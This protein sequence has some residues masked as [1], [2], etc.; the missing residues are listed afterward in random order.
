MNSYYFL[1][2][3]HPQ[4]SLLELATVL[5]AHGI[6]YTDSSINTG[7]TKIASN[8]DLSKIFDQIGG[9]VKVYTPLDTAVSTVSIIATD[10]KAHHITRFALSSHSPRIKLKSIG[11]QVKSAIPFRTQFKL[12][13]SPLSSVGINTNYTEYCIVNPQTVLKCIWAQNIDH[14][15]YKDRGRPKIDAKS[16]MLPLKIARLMV[17][18]SL[19]KPPSSKLT[20]YDPFCGSG[21]ILQEG[22]DL[23]L[24]VIGSDI[25]YK[26]VASSKSNLEWYSKKFNPPGKNSVFQ[27]DVT[28][29]D[30]ANIKQPINSIVFEG[31]LGPPNLRSDQI[32]NMHK[33]LTNLYLGTLK[34][35]S[36]LLAKGKLLVCAL[37]QYQHQGSVK[38]FDSLI[39]RCEKFGYTPKVDALTY[40][41]PHAKIK[42][43]IYVLCKDH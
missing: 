12:L 42:R 22:L 35:L 20:L 5:S 34:K 37:P 25:N 2:G 21:S 36:P 30:P 14:W 15:D 32:K 10:I 26:A 16:G 41:R 43:S 38:T 33:G 9:T 11:S 8:Q 27:Q 17:N 24:S 40:S 19:S 31:Y 3:K 28:Q 13:Q 29:L 1:L 39:D 23:G 6:K 18:L 4:L 7:L